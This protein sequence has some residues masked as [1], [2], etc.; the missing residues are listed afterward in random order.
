M[1]LFVNICIFTFLFTVLCIVFAVMIINF[2]K[3]KWLSMIIL[4]ILLF[5][6]NPIIENTSTIGNQE[7]Y[8]DN[9]LKESRILSENWETIRDEAL[10]SYKSYKTI[11][12]D[13]FFKDDIIKKD[14]EWKKLYIKWYTN[15]IDKVALEKCPKTCKI[16]ESLPTVKLA[17]ISVLSPGAKIYP[18]SGPFKGCLRYHLGLKTPNSDKCYISVNG[19]K[20][21]WRDGKGIL[22]DDTYKHWVINDTN[23]TRIILFCDIVRPTN[24]IGSFINNI[25]IDNFGHITTRKNK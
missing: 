4:S 10:A 24:K 13:M 20:Y 18:H 21:S 7:Y 12:G 1:S 15:E 14:D 5:I 6:I 16:I 19:K 2:I 3:I 17:M 8:N 11:R 22:L 23:E 25:F 9:I